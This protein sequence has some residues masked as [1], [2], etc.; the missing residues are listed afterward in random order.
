[1]R[2]WAKSLAR[3]RPGRR[4]GALLAVSA[5]AALSMAVAG[6]ALPAAA[7]D[8]EVLIL[9]TTVTGGTSSIE[10]SEVAAKGLTPV[11]VDDATWKAMGPGQFASYRAIILGDPTCGGTPPVA[12]AANAAT[13][14]GAISGNIVIAGT[15]PVFHQSQGGE[16]LTRRAVDVAV[17]QPGKTGLY[18][19]LSCYYESSP[20]DTAV[21]LLDG[22]R[23]GAFKVGSASCYNDSHIVATHPALAGLT[24]STLSNWS[25][26]VHEIFTAWPGDFSVLAIAKDFNA[27]FTASDGTVG[28]PYILASGAGIRSFPLSLSPTSQS[29]ATG[30]PASVTAQ[31]LDGT[32]GQ[33]VVGTKLSFR[34]SAGPN[35]GT[36]GS[37]APSTCATDSAGQVSWTYRGTTVGDDTVQVF[38]DSN[39]NGSPDPGEPQ[40]TG[41]VR[42]TT[43]PLP[44]VVVR[45]APFD[46]NKAQRGVVECN[47]TATTGTGEATA[48]SNFRTGLLQVSAKARTRVGGALGRAGVGVKYVA[49]RTGRIKIDAD[50][51]VAGFDW[52][53]S[54]GVPKLD[55]TAIVSLKSSAQISVSRFR[56]AAK[57]VSN[58]MVFAGRAMTPLPDSPIPMPIDIKRYNPAEPVSTSVALDV[59]KGQEL[60]V[61]VGVQTRTIATGLLPWVGTAAADYLKIDDAN[62]TEVRQIRITSVR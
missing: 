39:V 40:T 16:T 17:S 43:V 18:V 35:R 61:C 11:V 48:R 45:T 2:L 47:H 53:W 1:M 24:D 42:W 5:L 19:A 23:P 41:L 33:P 28:A 50:L 8:T 56:P 20:V 27:S 4:F 9:G 62:K 59:E 44:P 57:D 31:L 14:G 58:E 34:I 29:V 52:L 13:W 10:A 36:S 22:L 6:S 51:A 37:C 32:T 49:P 60:F 7:A 3:T 12:A 15:D 54:F 26:S 38:V 30:S 25:C 21:P 46:F 55:H